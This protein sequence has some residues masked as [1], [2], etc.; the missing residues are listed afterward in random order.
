[1][2]PV[3][4][5]KRL[6]GAEYRNRLAEFR[7]GNPLK[8]FVMGGF[9]VLFWLGLYAMFLGGFRFVERMVNDPLFTTQLIN[10][11]ISIFFFSLMMLLAFSN[12]IIMFAALFRSKETHYL[13]V[14]P[15][16]V[17][18]IFTYKFLDSVTV[19]SWA[20]LFLGTPFM[21]AYGVYQEAAPMFYV[22]ILPLFLIFMFVPAGLGAIGTLLVC[23]FF[24]R[25]KRG[26]ILLLVGL[27]AILATIIVSDLLALRG[28]I[29]N[30]IAEVEEVYN[31]LR[32][33]QHPLLP[34]YWMT[35]A[36]M[37]FSFRATDLR[38]GFVFTGIL[39]GN[40][41][42]VCTLAYWLA[43]RLYYG[44]WY[45]AQGIKRNK[46]VA[47]RSTMN[48][49]LWPVLV[50]LPKQVRLIVEKDIKTFFRDPA[51]WSQ[52]MIFFGLLTVYFLN[53]R[54]LQYD[55]RQMHWKNL[56][57]QLNL[58]ATCMTLSTF[59]SRFVFPQISLE[60]PRFWSIGMAP[61]RHREIIYGKFVYSLI[62]SVLIAEVLVALSSF[63]LKI[64]IEIAFLHGVTVFAVC[65]GL[66]GLAVGLGAIYPSFREDNPSRIIS[67][68]GGTL[69][70][71]L[72]FLFV[73]SLVV[74]QAVPCFKFYS[75]QSGEAGMTGDQFHQVIAVAVGSILLLGFIVAVIPLSRGIKAFERLEI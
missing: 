20:F 21:V 27:V 68:F 3:L 36:L 53:L 5:W 56:I 8:V 72:S 30:T 73:F 63:M 43:W 32:F 2:S 6:R 22:L 1:M 52:F 75:R 59:T 11:V 62:G 38:E 61:M 50:L 57:A 48:T 47:D 55:D 45:I 15:I 41:L 60:G 19:S 39:L 67:G 65:L 66:S 71:V 64:P 4:L 31:A 58:G 25:N 54:T 13:M 26:I 69:N 34:S 51:Q 24:P 49:L 40:A 42:F 9:A 23:R 14:N 74:I 17:E 46:A 28:K 29:G 37:A 44:S 12:G 7:K 70:L 18:N 10:V 35:K 33:S 16:P